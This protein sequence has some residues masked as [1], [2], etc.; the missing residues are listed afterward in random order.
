MRSSFE[1]VRRHQ[2]KERKEGESIKEKEEKKEG[3]GAMHRP[4]I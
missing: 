4:F 3:A 1:K 2:K